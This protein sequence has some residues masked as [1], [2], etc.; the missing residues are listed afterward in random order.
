MDYWLGKIATGKPFTFVRYGDGE[1]NAL[2]WTSRKK[3]GGRTRNGDGHS[4]RIK[5]MRRQMKKSIQQ[6]GDTPEYYRSVWM[7][8]NC[9]PVE[10]LAQEHLTSISPVGAIWYNALA[11]HFANISG[12]A[13][14]YFKLMRNLDMPLIIIGPKHLRKLPQAGVFAYQGFVEVPYRRAYFAQER[15]I[16]EALQF[17]EPCLYSIHAG[18]PSPILAYRLWKARGNTCQILDL[19]SLLDGYVSRRYGGPVKGGA[20]ITRKFW[21]KRATKAI[22]RRNLTGK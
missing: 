16:E 13:H 7:N 19:G 3:G 15:I 10:R 5:Q 18:P 6:P 1:L 22:L 2:F 20:P 11:I 21:K 17:P 14:P 4:L 9:Q 12:N 8:G